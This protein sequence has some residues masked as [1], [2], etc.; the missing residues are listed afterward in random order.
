MIRRPPRST[1]FPYTT[2]FR[3]GGA[4]G[5]PLTKAFVS[6]VVIVV[7]FAPLAIARYRRRIRSEEHTSELQSHSDLVCR[8]LLEK[9]KQQRITKNHPRPINHPHRQQTKLLH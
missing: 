5:A 7:V 3:S 8:L 9:K 2:L 4:V 1:L 6:L